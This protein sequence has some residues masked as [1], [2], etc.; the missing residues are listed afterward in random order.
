MN[1]L[2][3]IAGALGLYFVFAGEGDGRLPSGCALDEGIA[4]AVK[5][6]VL[7][8]LNEPHTAD[9]HDAAAAMLEISGH[10]K[11]A[12]CVRAQTPTPTMQLF[13]ARGFRGGMRLL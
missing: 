5:S 3:L 10:P 6:Q 7:A 11:A 8:F 2:L 9:E 13:D 12:A 1:P 4:S